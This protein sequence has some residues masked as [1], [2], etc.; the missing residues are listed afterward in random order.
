MERRMKKIRYDFDVQNGTFTLYDVETGKDWYNYLWN[1][2]GY[3]M[4]VSHT[5][6]TAS[7]Y[8]DEKNRQILLDCPRA[9][10]V[11]IRDE[12][13]GHYWNPGITP[14]CRIPEDYR[15]VHGQDFSE[16]TSDCEGIRVSVGYKVEEDALR[17]VWRVTLKN[18]VNYP[19]KI[20]VFAMTVFDMNGYEQNIYYSSNITSATQFVPEANAVF[21]GMQNPYS[22]FSEDC[23]YILSSEKVHAFDGNLEKF[24]G[25]SGTHTCPYVL[26]NKLDCTGS[27]ATVRTRAGILQNKTVILPGEEIT[28]YYLLGFTDTAERLK[29]EY[30]RMIESAR[31]LFA[32]HH[33]PEEHIGSRLRTSS[34]EKRINR[35]MNFWAAK[36]VSYCTI[37]KKA[38]RDNAQ[39]VLGLLNFDLQR[40][41]EVLDECLAHQYSDGH[42][43]LTYYPYLEKDIYSDPGFWL[44]YAVC[45]YVKETGDFE[46]LKRKV[47]YLDKETDAVYDHLKRAADWYMGSEHSGPN[48]LPLIFHADWNDA[49]NI[50]DEQAESVLMAM[51]V[52]FGLK[53]LSVLCSKLGDE[54]YA[55]K[56]KN[57]SEELARKLNQIAWNGD[58]YVRAFSKFGETGGKNDVDGPRIYINPQAWAILAEVVPKDRLSKMLDAMD[59]METEEGIPLCC[60]PYTKYDERV[61]RM[62]GQLQGI[63]ENGGIYNHA[64]CFKVMADCKLKRGD[65]AIRTLLEIIPDGAHNPSIVTT[66]EPYVFTNC[67]LKHPTVDMQVSFSWQ[68][69]TSA[70]GLRVYY[71]G[72]LGLQRD[73]DG[74]RVDP[75][76]P[77]GWKEVS[78]LREF[79]GDLYKITY[80]QT[81]RKALQILADG[82]QI[83]GN[84]LPVFGDGKEH[85]VLV[86]Y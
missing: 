13:T 65:H 67:Y 19:R 27:L 14:A 5:G 20:S 85:D 79:R 49:L 83:E 24:L 42:A 32:R 58:Y 36:Q 75:A 51:F 21:C 45:E 43:V 50:P 64:G 4:S 6:W 40:A 33:S 29:S 63:Y 86:E 70:W 48:G 23:G 7:K 8:V 10:F 60:P 9:N 31:R 53:E 16:I 73:Y 35:I 55:E 41:K 38:V 68:T 11:Y 34:P 12:E 82:K 18:L 52:C 39:L 78:A 26:E 76:L 57:F 30:S 74:L 84:I 66:T 71:E 69:G 54:T 22:P 2:Q 25:T 46:Y 1:R 61:G 47:T 77:S 59:A 56:L 28:L 44:I 37:G 62:S 15:C 81:G 80:R 17:E 3:M 72:I